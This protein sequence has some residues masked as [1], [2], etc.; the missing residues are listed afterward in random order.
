MQK[1]FGDMPVALIGPSMSKFVDS[2]GD[3]KIYVTGVDAQELSSKLLIYTKTQGWEEVKN[4]EITPTTFSSLLVLPSAGTKDKPTVFIFGGLEKNQETGMFTKKS[5]IVSTFKP[6]FDD[7]TC[8]TMS[9]K[10]ECGD[11]F[12][13]NQS[14]ELV[15]GP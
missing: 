9:V 7:L 11:Y 13:D 5:N 3:V 1:S 12:F 2:A 8:T 10:D 14:L 6:D 15:Q 4:F